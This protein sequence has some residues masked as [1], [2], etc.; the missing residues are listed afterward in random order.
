MKGHVPNQSFL[1]AFA[2]LSTFLLESRA[3]ASFNSAWFFFMRL[4]AFFRLAFLVRVTFGKP[5]GLFQ[6]LHTYIIKRNRD[7]DKIWCSSSCEVKPDAAIEYFAWGV[8]ATSGFKYYLGNLAKWHHLFIFDRK[9]SSS[10]KLFYRTRGSHTSYDAL[11]P[12][13]RKPKPSDIPGHPSQQACQAIQSL[14]EDHC[15]E[16]NKRIKP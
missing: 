4:L 7:H 16:S 1:S 2:T 6:S 12:E 11:Y 15:L 14:R 10:W 13:T 8:P 5:Q 9:H 3:A